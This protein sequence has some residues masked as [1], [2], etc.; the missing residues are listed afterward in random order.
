MITIPTATAITAQLWSA[1]ARPT[2]SKVQG[3][4]AMIE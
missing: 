4:Q 2:I 3:A 1:L